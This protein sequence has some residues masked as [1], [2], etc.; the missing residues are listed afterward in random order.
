MKTILVLLLAIS[1]VAADDIDDLIAEIFSTTTTKPVVQPVTSTTPRPPPGQSLVDIINNYN[2]K[3][4]LNREGEQSTVKPNKNAKLC[5]NGAGECVPYYLCANN[6]IITDGTG[7]IDIRFQEDSPCSYLEV[8]CGRGGQLPPPPGGNTCKDKGCSGGQIVEKPITPPPKT[9]TGCGYRN[10]NGVGFKI[11]GATDHEAE[12]GE[13]PWMVAVL[14]EEEIG[15]QLLNVYQCG[16]ALITPT[17]VLTAAHCVQTFKS[18]P[19]T[20][21]I[22]AGEWDTQTKNELFEHQDRNVYE[23]A[24]H[25]HYYKGGL[26]ND[27]ALLFLS[28]PI[29]MSND[30][31]GTVCLPPKDTNFDY[32]R[33]FASGWGKDVFGQEGKYQVILKKVELPIVP[34][35]QCQDALRTTRLSSHFVLHASFIC[36]GGEP[37]KDTCK[38]D[39]G[40]PLVCPIPGTSDRFYQAGIVAWGIGCGENHIPGVY[41]NVA[42]FRDWIDYH[43]NIRNMDRTYYEYY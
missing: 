18:D 14:R 34:Y 7:V 26:Y 38:G 16:G 19:N 6:E 2:N 20:L 25:E 42:G 13:F 43:L 33:C 11:T 28:Q 8:C 3:N 1:L 36:A 29:D 10:A 37:G 24:V 9:Q 39:G 21:K 35:K 5:D 17:V 41:V 4:P 23:I 12:Y 32:K 30:H 15:G 27:V 22:R 31:I 40:S